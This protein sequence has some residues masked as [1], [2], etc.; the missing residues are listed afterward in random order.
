MDFSA[1]HAGFVVAS[2]ALSAV[3]IAGLVI[4]VIAR[5]RSLRGEANRLDARRRKAGE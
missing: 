5:D 2:Y 1:P 4:Y 3:L